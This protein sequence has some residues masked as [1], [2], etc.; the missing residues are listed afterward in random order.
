MSLVPGSTIGAFKIQSLLGKGGMGEVFSAIDTRVERRV[1]L[2]VLPQEFA[3]DADRLRRFQLEARTL[4]SLN[5]PNVALLYGLEQFG[6]QSLLVL[7]LVEGETL[8][9]RLSRGPLP[10]DDALQIA[11][12]IAAGLEAAHEK[13]IIHRDLKP[14]NI[15][16]T[17]EDRAKV[18]DFGL[19]KLSAPE[20]SNSAAVL[21]DSPTILAGSTLPGLI[22]GTAAYMSP[23]QAK[24][25]TVDKRT[26]IFSFGCVLYE[27]LTG[28][29]LFSGESATD[30][31][32]AVLHKEPDWPL[33][34]ANTPVSIQLLLRRCL[35]KD[36]SKRLHDIADARLDLEAALNGSGLNVL[37]PA[38][39][40][41]ASPF[42]LLAC[43]LAGIVLGA[44]A[45]SFFVRKDAPARNNV[46]P[47]QALVRVPGTL[48]AG[49]RMFAA[50]PDGLRLAY[51]SE[52][53]VFIRKLTESEASARQIAQSAGAVSLFWS[54]D[55]QWLGFAVGKKLLRVRAD[56][57]EAQPIA[58]AREAFV[59][60][61]GGAWLRDNR[62][63]F[64]AGHGTNGLLQVPATGGVPSTF[65]AHDPNT[66]YDFHE[67]V[68]MPDGQSVLFI[69]HTGSNNVSRSIDTLAVSSGKT[70]KNIYVLPGGNGMGSLAYSR[71]GHILFSGDLSS[72]LWALPFDLTK[73][74]ASGDPILVYPRANFITI[75]NDGTLLFQSA[76]REQLKR[77]ARVD[78]TGKVLA[79]FGVPQLYH[80]GSLRLSGDRKRI[81]TASRISEEGSTDLWIQNE[82]NSY[83]L[84]F[85]KEGHAIFPAWSPDNSAVT[86]TLRD[87]KDAQAWFI[88][89]LPLNG[90]AS[91][92]LARG[93]GGVFT[94]GSDSV[95][96]IYFEKFGAGPYEIRSI[97][98]R[99]DQGGTNQP[100][101][102]YRV[103]GQS[104]VNLSLSPDDRFLAFMTSGQT[105]LE[106]LYITDFPACA[107]KYRV[108]SP[109]H[110]YWPVWRKI[111]NQLVLYFVDSDGAIHEVRVSGEGEVFSLEQPR[112]L[113][114]SN[115]EG[116][117][118]SY[119]DWPP[120]FDVSADGEEFLVFERPQGV[121][122]ETFL[123]MVQ[124]F[125]SVLMDKDK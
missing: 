36:R 53:R 31:I 85:V 94:S 104:L 75:A 54:P 48:K 106:E 114:R 45:T 73:L 80:P 103:T 38:P 55:S 108:N 74:R 40:R 21:A 122:R 60:A 116:L 76:A 20:T 98:L 92:R 99:G 27:C 2:K 62:I 24:G 23:E 56:S 19:A 43:L 49:L 82:T 112:E 70:R 15:K 119:R 34:P 77:F 25:K 50:S 107:R 79:Q 37:V 63:I 93:L 117:R 13:G 4:A 11:L 58:E 115:V 100:R 96:Y 67:P 26:D 29:R 81:L 28:K 66:D 59:N 113:F 3:A 12:Q 44:L 6:S 7:E 69:V 97:S 61:G 9:D 71:S 101:T 125:S 52:D 65:L 120:G 124:N 84:T 105:D 64:T 95:V 8:A 86:F 57:T 72:A 30:C 41:K 32:A 22:L 78:R 91:L 51:V 35:S 16:I 90:A 121:P 89:L 109:K 83:Q 87:N 39:A 102:H 123:T 5:H 68:A 18:L 1:A 47:R 33:L 111:G 88:E 110:A 118:L 42:V 46:L 10:I 14:A 17:P